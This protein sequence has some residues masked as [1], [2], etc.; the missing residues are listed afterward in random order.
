VTVLL[1]GA[2]GTLGR[3][4]AAELAKRGERIRALVRSETRVARLTTAPAELVVADLATEDGDLDPACRGVDTVI[5]VAGRSCSTARLPERGRFRPVDLDGNTRLLGAAVKAGVARF[6]YVSVLNAH[7]LRGLEYVDA[8]EEF[9][10][11]LQASP[12]QSTVVRANGFFAG[13]QEILRLIDSPGPVPLIGHGDAKDNPIHEADLAVACLEA[14]EAARP[15]VDVGGPET[16]TRRQ[17]LELAFQAAGRRP[18][19]IAVPPRLFRAGAA[20]LRPLDAR[21][22]EVLK[23]VAEIS[24][25]D[26]IGPPSGEH[27]LKDYLSALTHGR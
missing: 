16:F 20:A 11:L 1:A 21:R 22:G 4:V 26:M 27:T 12:L 24:T 5:S 10:Q 13:F 18:R 23:F 9:A 14:L 3:E 2:T 17:E 7:R 19:I 6:L 15:E 25:T 8:H